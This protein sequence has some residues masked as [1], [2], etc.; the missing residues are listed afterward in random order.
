MDYHIPTNI[1]R[2]SI[3]TEFESFFQNL[4]YDLSNMPENVISK[5]KTK[6]RNTYEKCRLV[7]VPYKQKK[8]IYNLS[9]RKDIVI[10]KEDKGRGVVIMDHSKYIEKCMSFLSSNHFK[11]LPNDPT[12]YNGQFEK[13]SQNCMSKKS[14]RNC[15]QQYPA[16]VNFMELLRYTNS[17]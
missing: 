14:T 12:K 11:H 16:Q 9:N 17:P 10:L 1:N 13:L 4:L 2:N 15:I 6:L 8:I 3:K 5:V 7:K